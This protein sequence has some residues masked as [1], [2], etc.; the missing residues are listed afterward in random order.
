MIK[1]IIWMIFDLITGIIVAIFVGFV[2]MNIFLKIVT[3]F[4]IASS[5]LFCIN[6]RLND[7]NKILK[8]E[9][10]ELIKEDKMLDELILKQK[11]RIQELDKLEPKQ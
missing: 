9:L 5:T 3:I 1:N 2:D 6:N 7:I 11:E 10:D 8:K 4:Y